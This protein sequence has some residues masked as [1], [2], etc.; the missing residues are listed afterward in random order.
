MSGVD[1]DMDGALLYDRDRLSDG[2]CKFSA[3]STFDVSSVY[4][5]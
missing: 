3:T 2:S 4:K 5:E 1:M